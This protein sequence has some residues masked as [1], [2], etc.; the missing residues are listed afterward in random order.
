MHKDVLKFG[1]SERE[2]VLVRDIDAER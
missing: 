1:L 2:Y